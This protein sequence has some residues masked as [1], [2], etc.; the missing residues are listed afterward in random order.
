M[1]IEESTTWWKLATGLWKSCA[2]GYAV[3][4]CNLQECHH[5]W[6]SS[7]WE[8][9]ISCFVVVS[10]VTKA[11][12][13]D[14]ARNEDP[15][16]VV[17]FLG[18][19]IVVQQEQNLHKGTS[20]YWDLACEN[21]EQLQRGHRRGDEALGGGQDGAFH[22]LNKSSCCK[23]HALLHGPTSITNNEGSPSAVRTVT[24]E[25]RKDRRRY[26][27]TYSRHILERGGWGGGGGQRVKL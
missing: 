15:D 22:N 4:C 24:I 14:V 19:K 27:C 23:P 16:C 1:C 26:Q 21:Q 18:L 10:E 20:K 25:G 17:H 13:P 8:C 5:S 9:K 6:V 7:P 2:A 12:H 3:F 11:S